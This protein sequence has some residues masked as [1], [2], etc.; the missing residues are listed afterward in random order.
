MYKKELNNKN[1]T[2]TKTLA[3]GYG[4]LC[5]IVALLV[6]NYDSLLQ[7]CFVVFGIVGGP[8]FALYTS[9]IMIPF[10][11]QFVSIWKHFGCYFPKQNGKKKNV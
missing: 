1:S 5:L 8:L 10:V 4:F 6:R 7:N 11:N 3:M 9:G 2:L